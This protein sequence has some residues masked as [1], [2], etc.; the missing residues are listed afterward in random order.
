MYHHK[1]LE[2]LVTV[3]NAHGRRGCLVNMLQ[4]FSFNKIIH[5]VEDKHA[6]VDTLSRNL[7]GM[8][9]EDEAFKLKY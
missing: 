4:D 1:P 7:G 9:K 5:T 8:P 3:L 6:N 2:W